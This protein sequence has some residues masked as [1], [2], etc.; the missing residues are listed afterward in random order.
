MGQPPPGHQVG[1]EGPGGHRDGE[2]PGHLPPPRPPPAALGRGTPGRQRDRGQDR[3]VRQ[4]VG[5]E[6][7]LVR[8]LPHLVGGVP[9]GQRADRGGQAL[10]PAAPGE[11]RADQT[12]RQAVA[13]PAEHGRGQVGEHDQ[14]GLAGRAGIEQAGPV[15]GPGGQGQLQVRGF[16]RRAGRGDQQGGARGEFGHDALQFGVRG[17]ESHV[18]FRS[19]EISQ[20]HD[21]QRAAGQDRRGQVRRRGEIGGDVAGRSGQGQRGPGADGGGAAC[22][23]AEQAPVGVVVELPVVAGQ[24]GQGGDG[25]APVA[26][27]WGALGPG[28]DHG[29]ERAAA[30]VAVVGLGPGAGVQ[31][32]PA[33]RRAG[34]R[35]HGVVGQGGER[36]LAGQ[37]PQ[38][39]RAGRRHVAPPQAGQAHDD[40]VPGRG[41]LRAGRV[42]G[43]EDGSRGRHGRE[44]TAQQDPPHRAWPDS[45]RP[46]VSGENPS[47]R[48]IRGARLRLPGGGDR[49]NRRGQLAQHN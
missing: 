38:R 27:L 16:G 35:E 40:D 17:G 10:R 20:V 34:D 13:E 25:R 26:G 19:A 6:E 5:P 3:R 21:G 24:A 39:G 41:S 28:R 48:T 49:V 14:A 9:A 1:Q 42:R 8:G 31:G 44:Q 7:H 4:Y 33:V 23:A 12:G 45:H 36:A 2:H 11:L 18:P 29:G 22:R 47:V 32:Q 37:P 30:G 43:G 46:T 15:P